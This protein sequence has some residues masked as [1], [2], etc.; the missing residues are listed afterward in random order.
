MQKPN[1][2]ESVAEL[3]EVISRPTAGVIELMKNLDGDLLIIGVSGK[4]GPSLAMLAQRAAAAA[5]CTK[6]IIGVARF[7]DKAARETLTANGI[8][9]IAGDLLDATAIA[10]LPEVENVVFMAG[11][12]FGSAGNEALTWAINTH[13]IGLVAQKFRDAK[14]VALSTGNVYPL[15]PVFSGGCRETDPLGPIGEYAQSAL[16]RERLLE[17]FSR[18]NRTKSVI[19][20]L[21]YAID[22]RYGTLLDIAQRVFNRQT[23]DL[24]MGHMNVIWQG[25][26][27]AMIL[28][29]F[30]LADSPPAILNVTGPELVSIRKLA[31]DFGAFFG[32]EPVFA[33]TESGT[34]LLSDASRCHALFGYPTVTLRQMVEWVGHWVKIGGPTLEKPTHFETRDGRF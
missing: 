27:N 14:I 22:L 6:K 21:N 12:K 31:L 34:A 5:G 30:A 25:D 10:K 7:S 2:I 19:V 32:I 15:T 1:V 4:M 11:T 16:G 24:A 3:D 20:R 23:I 13:V 18:A 28:R 33:N 17:Y 29:C 8:E 9:T 26:A